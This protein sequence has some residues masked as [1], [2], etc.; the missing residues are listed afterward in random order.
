MTLTMNDDVRRVAH[1]LL[2]VWY[3]YGKGYEDEAGNI[4]LEHRNMQAG[5]QASDLLTELGLG[6]DAGYD[7]VLNAAGRALLFD[8]EIE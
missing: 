8:E 1:H 4:R 6:E 3:Q 5:E 2:W 7:F